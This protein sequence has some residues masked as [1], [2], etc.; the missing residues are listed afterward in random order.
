MV[1][2]FFSMQTS[3]GIIFVGSGV[4][5]CIGVLQQV[6][7]IVDPLL[8]IVRADGFGRHAADE[9]VGVSGFDARRIGV[10]GLRAIEGIC[11]VF[12]AAIGMFGPDRL[13]AHVVC[14]FGDRAIGIGGSDHIAER[15][16]C[17]AENVGAGLFFRQKACA[18]VAV[19]RG[20]SKG[21]FLGNFAA[22]EVV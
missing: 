13:A 19:E 7:T 15:I 17:I 2:P 18:V 12:D 8:L 14:G 3:C 20:V 21:F 11:P 16:A 10:A 4:S 22:F 9:I 6:L 5:F 1:G